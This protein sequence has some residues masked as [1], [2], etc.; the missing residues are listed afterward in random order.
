MALHQK[1]SAAAVLLLVLLTGCSQAPNVQRESVPSIQAEAMQDA[2]ESERLG[3]Q[4]GDEV[5]SPITT[6]DLRRVNNEPLEE[7]QVSYADKSYKG[8]A[9]NSMSLLAGKVEFSVITD[10]DK[11]PLYRDAGNYYL[12]GQAGQAYRLVYHNNSANTYEIVASVDGLNVL[13]GSAASLYDSGYVLEP[14]DDLVIEG[15]RKSQSAVASFIFSKPDNAYAANTTSGS[16]ENTGVIGT[17]IYELYDPSQ[18]KPR[19][20]KTYPA[21]KG[22]AKP[23]Q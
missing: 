2:A 8:R 1:Q 3:T 20:A 5:D 11:L 7:M 6:V 15:F 17:V 22:Y 14:N 10:N 9:V 16:I 23:P 18:P 4:W 19:H 21:D 13:N 12:Q